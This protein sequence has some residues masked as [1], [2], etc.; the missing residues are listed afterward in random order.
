[1]QG[2]RHGLDLK[3]N[4]FEERKKLIARLERIKSKSRWISGGKWRD[5]TQ[6]L[7]FLEEYLFGKTV[8]VSHQ[9]QREIA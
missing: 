7:A 8:A 2:S 6:A 4:R 5:G 1:M 3:N 9:V